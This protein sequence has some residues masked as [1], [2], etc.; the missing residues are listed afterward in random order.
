MDSVVYR[1]FQ[2][3]DSEAIAALIKRLYLEDPEEKLISNEKISRTFRELR[4]HPCKGVIFVVELKGEIAGYALLLNIWS[5]E[6]GGNIVNI[7]E[8]YVKKE[9]REKGIATNFITYLAT[10]KFH[11]AVAL[12][13]ETT[14]SNKKARSLYERLCFKQNK[15]TFFIREL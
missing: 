11:N 9:F 5:N 3:A 2:S 7:D 13:L 4:D 15:N 14:P 6:F 1:E 8:L 10:S 12:S